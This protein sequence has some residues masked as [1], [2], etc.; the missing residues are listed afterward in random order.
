M[1]ISS[2]PSAAPVGVVVAAAAASAVAVAEAVASWAAAEAE[3]RERAVAREPVADREQAAAPEPAAVRGCGP[4]DG[5]G[6]GLVLATGRVPAIDP[7]QAIVPAPVMEGHG[8]AIAGVTVGDAT[9][10]AA[11]GTSGRRG[12]APISTSTAMRRA[13]AAAARRD[14]AGRIAVTS[15]PGREA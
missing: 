4:T 6:I 10:A 9:V 11:A 2:S 8:T 5:P 12:L 15:A 13:I 14:T 1:V 7:V 3:G